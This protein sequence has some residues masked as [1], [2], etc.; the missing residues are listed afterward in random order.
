MTTMH[1]LLR[2]LL[3][4][5]LLLLDTTTKAAAAKTTDT[6]DD[7][8]VDNIKD[9]VI[10][11][12]KDNTIYIQTITVISNDDPPIYSTEI[13]DTD[14][15]RGGSTETRVGYDTCCGLVWRTLLYFPLD[16]INKKIAEA[17]T[18]GPSSPP[19]TQTSPVLVSAKI[20]FT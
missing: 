8:D 16:D 11:V 6:A 19:Q 13:R 7:I 4:L 17:E 14:C 2:V 12:T 3:L 9:I 5:S 20:Q 1:S 10:N 18:A 15:N